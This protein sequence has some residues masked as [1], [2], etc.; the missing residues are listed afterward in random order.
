MEHGI[1]ATSGKDGAKGQ[2]AKKEL[3]F[4]GNENCF[5]MIGPDGH[6][7]ECGQERAPESQ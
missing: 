1:D 2:P 6:C 3:R 7:N 4:C 5:G